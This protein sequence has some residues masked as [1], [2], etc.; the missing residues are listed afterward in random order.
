[1]PAAN[2]MQLKALLSEKFPGLRMRLDEPRTNT[3][4]FQPA[5]LPQIDGPLRGGLPKGALSEVIVP[6]ANCGCATLLQA[7]LRQAARAN[8][9]IA[10]IDGNDSLDVMHLDEPV[11]SRMLWI[12]CHAVADAIKSADLVLR[13]GNVP[14]VLLDLRSNA[15]NQLR[16]ISP[17]TWYRFQ[18]L[19]EETGAACIVFTSRRM[20]A[21]ARAR[22]CLRPQF[23]LAA[24]EGDA[25]ELLLDMKMEVSSPR[26]HAQKEFPQISS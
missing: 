19:V 26:E 15:E 20:V 10:L 3:H 1:M 16:K 6:A 11:L 18:R 2:V 9:I 22:I 7:L 12:R 4:K 17:A 23:S 14:Q 5:G 25:D 21:P 13:D 24:L 8:E